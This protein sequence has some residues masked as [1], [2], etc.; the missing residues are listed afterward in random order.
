M[1]RYTNLN[2]PTGEQ[3]RLWSKRH[4]NILYISYHLRETHFIKKTTSLKDKLMRGQNLEWLVVLD[5]CS[6]V[7]K[8]LRLE[9][10]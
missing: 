5:V 8:P 3:L 7:V 1:P 10:T 2:I 6:F 4:L 9:A